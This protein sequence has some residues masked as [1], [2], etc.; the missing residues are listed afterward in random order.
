MYELDKEI[1][2]IGYGKEDAKEIFRSIS[3]DLFH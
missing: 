2:E 1:K 3:T